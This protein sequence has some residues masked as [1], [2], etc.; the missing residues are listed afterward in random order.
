MDQ[1]ECLARLIL[2]AKSGPVTNLIVK[3]PQVFIISQ[4]IISAAQLPPLLPENLFMQAKKDG[5]IMPVRPLPFISQTKVS[6]KILKDQKKV[7][8]PNLLSNNLYYRIKINLSR[9][10]GTIHKQHRPIFANYF[11]K[12]IKRLSLDLSWVNCLQG[13][14]M[15]FY[16]ICMGLA[17]STYKY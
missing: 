5:Y 12:S 10:L 13:I 2:R 3:T 15:S 7:T 17:V 16:T 14:E 8:N 4:V 11:C 6:Y 1:E 9:L